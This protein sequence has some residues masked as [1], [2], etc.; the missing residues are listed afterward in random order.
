ML[1]FERRLDHWAAGGL[2]PVLRKEP[3]PAV[4]VLAEPAQRQRMDD[5]HVTDAQVEIV[6]GSFF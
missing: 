4:R 2:E 5:H 6:P 1:G 3:E